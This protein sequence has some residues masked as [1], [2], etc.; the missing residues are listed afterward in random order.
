MARGQ[1]EIA[2][3]L[4]ATD[5]R[6]AELSVKESTS[7][8][9]SQME[10]ARECTDSLKVMFQVPQ[11]WQVDGFQAFAD[12]FLQQAKTKAAWVAIREGGEPKCEADVQELLD[13]VH[14]F[15]SSA[16]EQPKRRESSNKDGMKE[17]I[18]SSIPRDTHKQHAPLQPHFKFDFTFVASGSASAGRHVPVE[19]EDVTAVVELKQ[20]LQKYTLWKE[21]AVQVSDGSVQ[22]FRKQPAR[23]FMVRC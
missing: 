15:F 11:A 18:I 21:A 20:S 10:Q 1:E 13:V 16:S 5:A 9:V 17:T 2:R 12:W 19:W 3:V 23:S 4:K 14:Q 6:M 22:I 7:Q 8:I